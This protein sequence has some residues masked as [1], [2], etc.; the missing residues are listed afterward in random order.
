MIPAWLLTSLL[1]IYGVEEFSFSYNEKQK[2]FIDGKRINGEW[3][4]NA[5][6]IAMPYFA[7]GVNGYN[8]HMKGTHKEVIRYY[9]SIILNQLSEYK[10]PDRDKI[11]SLIRSD[12]D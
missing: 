6:V 11:I 5:Y 9:L 4:I 10:A 3:I 12:L 2:I 7:W 1:S 8:S